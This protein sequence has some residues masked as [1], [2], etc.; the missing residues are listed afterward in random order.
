MS[1]SQTITYSDDGK[2]AARR[3]DVRP[4]QI[5]DISGEQEIATVDFGKDSSRLL[6]LNFSGDILAVV[7]NK[8][9]LS[10][11]DIKTNK[12]IHKL[13]G[14]SD[15]INSVK[16]S[17]DN[18]ILASAARDR[19]IKLWNIE[20][21]D[22]ITSFQEYSSI[23]SLAFHP[24]EPILASGSED[25]MI[26]LWNTKKLQK[27][28]YYTAY[29]KPK[30]ALKSPKVGSLRFSQDGNYLAS[31]SSTLRLWKFLPDKIFQDN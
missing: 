7:T 25:G 4:V 14:H 15:Y 10:L 22:L 19:M 27:E 31:A 30:N 24:V 13:K 21:G 2:I 20:T 1:I 3:Y 26:I 16:F 6:R 18:K 17:P 11:W 8:Y 9:D 12:L 23:V 5:W 29:P 28:Y